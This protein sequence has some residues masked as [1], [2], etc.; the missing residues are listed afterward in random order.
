MR[1]QPHFLVSLAFVLM[2]ALAGCGGGGGGS[3]GQT[4]TLQSTTL[5]LGGEAAIQGLTM[6]RILASGQWFEP[7]QTFQPGDPPLPVSTF[8]YTL[9]QD[10]AGD[11]FRFDWNREVTFPFVQS[12]DYAE[13]IDGNLG[14]VDGVDSLAGAATAGMPA[15]RLATIRKLHRLNSP[16]LLLRS[17]LADPASVEMRPDEPFAGRIHQVFAFTAEPVSPVRLF[18]DPLTS[19]P[20]KADTLQDDPYYG[21][22]LYEVLYEDWRPV[23][24]VMVPHRLTFRLTGLGRTVTVRTEE[25]SSVENGVVLADELFAIPAEL[26]LPFYAAD[27]RRGERMAQWFLRRQAIGI[28]TYADQGL[29]L[30]FAETRPGSGVFFATGG[31]HN[32]LIVE[33]ADHLI[34]LEPPLYE[35]RSLAV[36]AAARAQFPEKPIRHVVVSHFHIDHGGGVRTYAAAGASVVVGEAV[37][38]HFE[39]I[40]AAPHTLVPDA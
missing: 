31:S 32:T 5:A 39:A 36:I 34:A 37:P 13:V 15:V 26:Q 1:I 14:L 6:Q 29:S 28:P 35:S 2:L 8:S 17:A 21:D 9:N 27:A 18:V 19:L 25:R 12:L 24:A 7:E 16:L 22:T 11:R 10:F 4:A 38:A 3:G 30:V 20:A 33:M 40:L 23:G